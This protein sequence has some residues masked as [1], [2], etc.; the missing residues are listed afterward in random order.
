MRTRL[1]RL[2]HQ[3]EGLC[4]CSVVSSGEEARSEP[5]KGSRGQIMQGQL[6][7]D[8]GHVQ[9]PLKDLEQ[10]FSLAAAWRLCRSPEQLVSGTRAAASEVWRSMLI[11]DHLRRQGFTGFPHG[12]DLGEE[13]GGKQDTA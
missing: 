4:D 3:R 6:S 10:E 9:G 8:K 1:A 13:K 12:V 2:R 7:C 5:R 11:Q